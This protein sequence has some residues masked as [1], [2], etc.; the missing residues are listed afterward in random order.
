MNSW[1]N[2]ELMN[3]WETIEQGRVDMKSLIIE[4][5]KSNKESM[6]MELL[7]SGGLTGALLRILATSEQVRST[8]LDGKDDFPNRARHTTLIGR[9]REKLWLNKK[10]GIQDLL[11]KLGATESQIEKWGK[12]N[13]EY[14]WFTSG[15]NDS[16][17]APMPRLYNER[18]SGSK[19]FS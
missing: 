13:R 18:E 17:F 9:I 2:M 15:K 5:W 6:P 19:F 12:T 1:E 16:V 8:L 3:T 7:K 10:W 11:T 14:H 4:T